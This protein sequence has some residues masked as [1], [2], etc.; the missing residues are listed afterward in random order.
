MIFYAAN[1]NKFSLRQSWT[2]FFVFFFA[3]V[4]ELNISVAA[5]SSR[6]SIKVKFIRDYTKNK[7]LLSTAPH[8]FSK[9][10]KYQLEYRWL[11]MS[12]YSCACDLD[13]S[14]V[15]VRQRVRIRIKLKA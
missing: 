8:I 14:H 11:S 15:G 6:N 4:L 7:I 12:S 3:K 10:I 1:W 13:G 2:F 9:Q 5:A